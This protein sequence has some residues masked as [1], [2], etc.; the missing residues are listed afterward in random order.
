M[1]ILLPFVPYAVLL[2][3]ALGW[4]GHHELPG[5]CW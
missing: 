3:V 2:S 1:R 5:V 4:A